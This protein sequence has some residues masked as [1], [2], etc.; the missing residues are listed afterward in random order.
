MKYGLYKIPRFYYLDFA[1]VI[2]KYG[3]DIKCSLLI[4]NNKKWQ[5]VLKNCLLANIPY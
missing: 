2:Y 3:F 4:V 1:T 5:Y